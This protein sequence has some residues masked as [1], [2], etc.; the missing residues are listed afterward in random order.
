MALTSGTR[1]GP[2]EI[3]APL[4]A[5]GMGEVY[6]ARHTRL[7]REVAIKVLPEHPAKGPQALARFE[8]EAKA[9]AALSHPNILALYDVGAHQ[10]V[11]YAVT[12]LLEGETLRARLAQSAIPWRKAVEIGTA[13]AEGLAAAH[14]KGIIHRDLKPE[15]IFLTSDDRIKILDFGL[16]RFSPQLS[17][18]ELTD[19]PTHSQ[20]TQAGVVMGTVPY[21]SPEQLRGQTTDAR[22]DIYAAGVVLYEMATG[23]RPFSQSQSADLIGAILHETPAPPSERNRRITSGLEMV[24]MKSLYKEPGNRYQSARELLVA[25]E[26]AGRQASPAHVAAPEL[27]RRHNL[28]A[29]LTSFVGRRKELLELPGALALSRLLSMTGAGGVGKTRLALRL[30]WDLVNQFP[31]GVWLV[32]LAPLSA[33]DLVAQTIATALG[34]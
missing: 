8:R 7:E 24:V 2:Y 16:A 33:P 4:G 1:L 32:D 27:P 26:G 25:L 6:R 31:D 15:N 9:V 12:E 30:A 11:S 19:A 3:L 28:P 22:S 20:L 29:E 14:S 18:Q 13:V 21:M 5:G 17:Q 34:V 23:Q 10:G